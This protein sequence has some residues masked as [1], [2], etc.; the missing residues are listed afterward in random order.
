MKE[1]LS[2]AL[3][4]YFLFALSNAHAQSTG[5]IAGVVRD[6]TGAVLPGV[7]VT[8]TNTATQESRQSVT[9]EAGRYSAPLL[10]AGGYIVRFELP[11]FRPVRR[12]GIVL[13]VTERIAVDAVL[14]VSTV[15]EELTITAESAL[16]QTE[17][18]TL[19]HVVDETQIRQLPLATRNFTQIL[20]LSSGTSVSVPDTAALG[21]GTL[22]I[23]TSGARM[24]FNNFMINGINANNIHTNSAQ[25]NSL[26]SNGV[27]IPASDTI[28]EFKV[29]TSLFDA[30]FG[31]NSGANVNVVTKSG[32]PQYH[33]NL[34]EFFRNEDLNANNFFFNKAGQRR[35]IL[36]QN[37]F[38]GTFGGPIIPNKTFFFAGYQGTR[39]TN[40][41]SLSA[42]SSTL[43]LPNIPTDRSAASLGAAFAGVT[44]SRGG[45]AVVSDGSNINPVALTLLNAKLADG[46]YVIPS[47]QIQSSGVNYAASIPATYTENQYT[48][49]V[50]HNFSSRNTLAW[51]SFFSKVPQIRPFSSATLP[52]FGYSQDFSN[53]NLSLADRHTFTPHLF[54]E[55]RVGYTRH[56]GVDILHETVSA[57]SVGIQRTTSSIYPALPLI[58]VTGAFTIGTGTNDDQA[59][60]TNTYVLG[61]TLSF[62]NGG[63]SM[64]MGFEVTRYQVNLYNNFATRGS[65]GFASFGDFLI[66]RAG[67][68]ID[69]GGNGTAFSNINSMQVGTGQTYHAYR[70][71]DTS[72]FWQDDWK[73][74]SRLTMNLGLRYDIFGFS[75]DKLGRLG[76]F[77]RR[78]YQEAPPNGQT[79][80]GFVIASN[81]TASAQGIPRVAPDMVDGTKHT[82]F[83]PRIGLAFK[84]IPDRSLVIRTGYGIFFERMANQI[85]LQLLSAPPFFYLPNL[86][87]SSGPQMTFQNPFGVLP[88]P[89]DFPIF[90][91]IYGPISPVAS[92]SA[93]WTTARP[94]Q[95]IIN[96]NPA[97][98]I[99]YLQHYSF[100]IQQELAGNYLLELGYVGSKGTKLPYSLNIN[101]AGEATA[102]NPIRGLTG[103][104]TA[105]VNLR[106]PYLGFSPTGVSEVETG[107]DSRYNSL[108]ASVTKRFSHG[109]QF[110][111]SYTWS[112]SLDNSSGGSSSTLGSVSGDQTNLSQARGLS[113]F[114]RRNRLVGTFI[115]ELPKFGP[116]ALQGWQFSGIITMQSGNPFT[117]T[118]STGAALYGV[119]SS[120]ANFASGASINSV[121]L[122]GRPQDR[123][124]RYFDTTGFAK[125]GNEFGNA[126]RNILIGPGQANV[127]FSIIKKSA[128]PKHETGNVEFRTEFFNLLN[129]ANFSA[130]NSSITSS[131]FG[132]ITTTSNNARL[133]QLALKV[134]F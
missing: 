10:P 121:T 127:D 7:G 53:E 36:R 123:L 24:V 124:T 14:E 73:F 56:R 87:S 65:L 71:P 64:R 108:Q 27:A 122:S 125:A 109:Y 39:Q 81:T 104:T 41:A 103:S 34:F 88:L 47:P 57:S 112:K 82:N 8:V 130:P 44:G 95:A 105:D 26:S 43:T 94:L 106:V 133:I 32:G 50:D 99:P 17:T 23:S 29:Q 101:Q 129:H 16:V 120:R 40:G 20:G 58:T 93:A 54:N 72:A 12:E 46:T 22:N 79:Q 83:A 66:G 89:S 92:P 107:T 13:N 69:Q 28:Q 37:Q 110:N 33:G 63:H 111:A 98:T 114:D 80:A 77:D 6:Q 35:P 61:D 119:T 85:S 3:C 2:F 52:G 100:G 96:I 74:S 4:F 55:L 97:L 116:R 59:G 15:A 45:L 91:Y 9:D 84:P 126:G 90:P 102:Q 76:N 115:G 18:V 38:G 60:T 1:R 134:N 68:P 70:I 113:D 67:T 75:T 131:T 78:L 25:E 31:R 5:T 48:I 128:L 30:E 49:N 62:V 132:Q 42:S 19:G 86:T 117:V 11:G 51:K 21:R 118:D